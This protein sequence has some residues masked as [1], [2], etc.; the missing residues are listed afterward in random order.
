[1][2]V[3]I[4]G[5][6]FTPAQA[7]IEELKQFPDLEITYIGRN[8]TLEGDKTLSVESQVL[9]KIGVKFQN[10]I[11]GRLQ[12][13]F[14]PYTIISWLKIPIGFIQAFYYLLV[15]KPNVVLSFGGYVGVPVVV[16]AWLLSIP[17]IVHEQTLVVGLANKFS[18]LFASKIAVSY[19]SNAK[20]N[21]KVILT[22]NPLRKE[23]LEENSLDSEFKEFLTRPQNKKLPLLLITGGNQGSH[24]INEVASKIVDKLV[25][26]YFV[27]H[28]T[29]DS[30]YQDF[31]VLS[32]LKKNLKHPDR[33][34]LKKWIDVK[35]W[36]NLLKRTDLAVSRAG[37]NTLYELAYFGVPVIVIPLPYLY[38]DEQ[39]KNA[40]YF[41]KM[42]LA[43]ILLQKNLTPESLFKKINQTFN[44]LNQ[45]KK[46]AKGAK[47]LVKE[48][49]AKKLAQE[50][51]LMGETNV[52]ET[53]I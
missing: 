46:D 45:I 32:G 13:N 52:K 22:G 31:E 34:L 37:A 29:G 28:Q 20:I 17:V 3:L 36:G 44:N 7:V 1:M 21:S 27:V 41:Q 12:R 48:E 9:P 40:L 49:A 53:K 38:K 50:V 11:A 6:H 15:D 2:R 4:T 35:D 33:Y 42:G 47:S 24:I 16:S 5:A 43:K 14:T 23:L 30:K 39:T 25:E 10:L 19:Q 26:N 51:L 18:N 8:K